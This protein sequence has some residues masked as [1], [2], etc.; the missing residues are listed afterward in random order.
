LSGYSAHLLKVLL[1]KSSIR[2]LSIRSL[3]LIGSH[4]RGDAD[5]KADYDFIA[6]IETPLLPIYALRLKRQSLDLSTK[7]GVK[8]S[9][10]PMP[11]FK[12][13][14]AKGNLF[15]LKAK[16]EAVLLAGE[17]LISNLD[18][19]SPWEIKPEWYFSFL[20]FLMVE[21]LSTYKPRLYIDVEVSRVFG[22]V[23]RSLE[24]L[25]ELSP[26]P[27]SS[28]IKLMMK[29]LKRSGSNP[30]DWFV[31]KDLLVNLFLILSE[32]FS[33]ITEG[34]IIYIIQRFLRINKG[35]IFLK[36][37]ESALILITMKRE[38]PTLRW[39]FSQVLVKDRLRAAVLLLLASIKEQGLDDQLIDEAY[40]ILKPCFKIRPHSYD[41]R[42]RW[43]ALKDTILS[44]WNYI[45]TVMGLL[46]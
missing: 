37:L 40:Y 5:E 9:I 41:T 2:H 4:A 14:H 26:P 10:N 13:K 17:D 6:I 8:I 38:L 1:N 23:K 32:K 45:H 21:L 35:I 42:A 29:K 43:E 31:L 28:L 7:F 30:E 24:D 46:D 44:Y 36:N 22:K 11:S 16:R 19:G 12:L 34:D 3:I 20:A 18:V 27:I 15:M 25:A 39:I 33:N